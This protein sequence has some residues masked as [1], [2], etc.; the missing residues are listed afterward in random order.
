MSNELCKLRWLLL[1]GFKAPALTADGGV[2]NLPPKIFPLSISSNSPAATV[3]VPT[4]REAVIS[5]RV[6]SRGWNRRGVFRSKVSQFS[7]IPD[8]PGFDYWKLGECL[9]VCHAFSR[10]Q[11]ITHSLILRKIIEVH[12]LVA[13]VSHSPS[14]TV[15]LSAPPLWPC[16]F[17]EMVITAWNRLDL[18][19]TTYNLV[20]HTCEMPPSASKCLFS[21]T[22]SGSLNS[23][24]G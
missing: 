1:T 18:S 5:E 4:L 2:M 10:S 24:S 6:C 13:G 22:R 7:L 8:E 17:R 16:D 14:P 15:A 23:S 21:F 12:S 9:R 11:Y 20:G 3:V 19:A